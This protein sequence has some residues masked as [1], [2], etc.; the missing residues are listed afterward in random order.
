MRRKFELIL[1]KIK[2]LKFGERQCAWYYSLFYYSLSQLFLGRTRLT[3]EGMSYIIGLC[4]FDA[5]LK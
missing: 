1:L 4:P 3:D 5:I 2:L